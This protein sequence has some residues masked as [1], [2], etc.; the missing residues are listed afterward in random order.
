MRD[1]PSQRALLIKDNGEYTSASDID[2]EH[3]LV[4]ANNAG[5]EI[6]K[7][8]LGHEIS[9][10]YQSLVVQRVLSA[11]MK[12]AEQNQRHTLFQSRFVIKG[13]SCKVIIDGESYNNLTSINMVEK[14]GL[15]T[16]QHPHPYYIQW[17]NSCGML[18]ATKLVHIYFYIGSYH[19]YVDCEVVSMQACSL[20]LGRPWQ[21]DRYTKHHGR[22]NRYTFTY[23]EKKIT[24]LPLSPVAILNDELERTERTSKQKTKVDHKIIAPS[25]IKLKASVMLAT[26]SDCTDMLKHESECYAMICQESQCPLE[27]MR[28]S[29][30]PVATNLLQEI[31]TWRK[32]MSQG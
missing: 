4:A 14:L 20:L 11:Q 7:E 3:V 29:L 30:P 25:E 2:K 28:V 31:M 26:K 1:C 15:T 10:K 24:L 16:T 22:S 18:R 12:L 32:Q 21:Y 19:D 6:E 5:D 17:Q 27:E 13:R 9:D 23:K 8:Q